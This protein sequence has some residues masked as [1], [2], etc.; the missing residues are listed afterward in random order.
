MSWE[1]KER[2]PSSISSVQQIIKNEYLLCAK[3]CSSTSDASVA[4][5]LARE[6]VKRRRVEGAA[7]TA[8]NNKYSQFMV[9]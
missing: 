9:C 4:Y 8:D 7:G 3:D 5:V 2:P 1:K 6:Q